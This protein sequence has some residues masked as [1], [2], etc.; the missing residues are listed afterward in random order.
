MKNVTPSALQT[1]SGCLVKRWG[2]GGKATAPPSRK[3]A[4]RTRGAGGGGDGL[5]PPRPLG[6]GRRPAG[7]RGGRRR[8]S[9][10]RA[11][12]GGQHIKKDAPTVTA[13]STTAPFWQR[14]I[15]ALRYKRGEGR[16]RGGRGGGAVVG[17]G[18]ERWFSKCLSTFPLPPPVAPCN[19]SVFTGVAAPVMPVA[20][21][22]GGD[23]RW[24][25]GPPVSI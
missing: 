7:G 14:G 9:T 19:F 12:V 17:G 18:G 1:D 13:L 16:A 15:R 11:G 24:G 3:H 10:G 6:G 20:R 21:S 23:K 2:G 25:E 4:P 8:R 5:F 22:G